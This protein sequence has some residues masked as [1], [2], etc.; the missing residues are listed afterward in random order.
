L[1]NRRWVELI[2]RLSDD[3]AVN[4]AFLQANDNFLSENREACLLIT[5]LIVG[6]KVCLDNAVGLAI[7]SLVLVVLELFDCLAAAFKR[8]KQNKFSPIQNI[9]E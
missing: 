2:S 5:N 3:G 7:H 8:C 6:G 4:F 1:W 9:V